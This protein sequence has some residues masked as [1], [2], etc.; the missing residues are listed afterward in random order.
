MGGRLAHA[1]LGLEQPDTER[2]LDPPEPAPDRGLVDAQKVAGAG[3]GALVPDRG[4]DTQIVPVHAV[5]FITGPAL[6]AILQP[7]AAISLHGGRPG[8][9]Y[10]LSRT[11]G[12]HPCFS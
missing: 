11:T 12:R 10:P 9:P 2:L 3:K 4:H 1:V 8:P 5:D 7:S 6:P